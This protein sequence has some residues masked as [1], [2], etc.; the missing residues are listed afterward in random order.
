MSDTLPVTTLADLLAHAEHLPTLPTVAVEILRLSRNEKASMQDLTAVIA[1]DP[2][3]S[4]KILKLANS[5]AFH[6]GTDVTSLDRATL[7]LGMT[8]VQFLTL[9]FSLTR[10]NLRHGSKSSFDYLQYWQYSI[11]MA[12]AG[13]ELGRLIHSSQQ[14]EAFLCGLL[15][16]FGQLVMAQAIPERYAAV[17]AAAPESLP[18]A[19][20][21][22]QLLGYDHHQVGAALMHDWQFPALLTD[23]IRSWEAPERLAPQ[24]PKSVQELSRLIQMADMT[25]QV[26]W[27][28]PKEQALQTLHEYGQQYFGVAAVAMDAC[29]LSLEA[30]LAETAA[31][32]DIQ[33]TDLGDF[34]T[35]LT[36]ARD[37]LV[38]LSL[39]AIQ[40]LEHTTARTRELERQNHYLTTLA[41]T[42]KLTGLYN[43]AG[44][45]VALQQVIEAYRQSHHD[46][47]LGL[48][49][50]DVDHFK[51]FNDT[52]GHL[53]GDEVL[54][55][56]ATWIKGATRHTDI[57]ARYGGEEFVVL[58]PHT[59]V[60]VLYQIAERIRRRVHDGKAVYEDR[61]LSV[62][63]SIGGACGHRIQTFE[64]GV[65]LLKRA[66][67]C[68]YE[69]KTS[70]RNRTVCRAMTCLVQPST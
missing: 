47:A 12:V 32:F 43:R 7:R 48:L 30:K 4:A 24:T 11:T 66:D 27:G 61:Q 36:E 45:E 5:T 19:A 68:L 57:V 38:Q 21:E 54:K 63:I 18:T 9:G 25:S 15:G 56:V 69:A 6:R 41:Q 67:A 59:T 20:L 16:R 42:D 51:A 10:S 44:F 23:T 29:F 65:D 50:L 3:L 40:T 34:Q 26:I 55:R 64:D 53:I 33:V 49:M 17:L 46:P 2:A 31:L 37:R 1:L 70:G 14:H 60:D 28:N 22:R 13:Q 8:T 52:Y 35:M 39:G 58:V 62:T